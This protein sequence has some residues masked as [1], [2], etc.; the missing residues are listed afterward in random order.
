MTAEPDAFDPHPDG[1]I[2]RVHAK[3]GRRSRGGG[4]AGRLGLEAAADGRLALTLPLAAPAQ[5]GR[6][7][8]ELMARLAALF[9][10]PQSRLSLLQGAQGRWKRVLIPGDPDALKARLADGIS[11][12]SCGYKG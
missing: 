11:S 5:E 9:G 2:L 12:K 4:G 8:A 7:N 1:L 10:V 6:A 3:P